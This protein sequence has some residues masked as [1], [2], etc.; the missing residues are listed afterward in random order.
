MDPPCGRPRGENVYSL[1]LSVAP[2]V[3]EEEPTMTTILLFVFLI[4]FEVMRLS[5]VGSLK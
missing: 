3:R 5:L 2:C 4:W 1:L